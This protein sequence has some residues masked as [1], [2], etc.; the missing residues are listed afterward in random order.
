[1]SHLNFRKYKL[2]HFHQL[3]ASVT[4]LCLLL[5]ACGSETL[6]PP[7]PPPPPAPPPNAAPQ[8]TS[9]ATA[10]VEERSDEVFYTAT[11]T[12]ANNDTITFSLVNSDDSQ[13]FELDV[14][15]GE[16]AFIEEADFETPQDVNQDNVYALTLRADDGIDT[17]DLELSVSVTDVT[18]I[19]V[20]VV[21]VAQGLVNPI[22]ATGA[23][24]NSNRLFVIE[25]EGF[26]RIL[27]LDDNSLNNAPFLDITGDVST[28]FEQGLLGLAF[29][30]DY[31]TSG[32]FY[33]YITNIAGDTE[34]LEYSVSAT[35]P[36]LADPTSRRL[37]LTFA[38]PFAN[39]NAGW[40]GFDSVGDLY[41]TSGD[42]G[43]A[44]DPQNNAQ[45]TD[46]LL[47]TILRIDPMGDDFPADPNANYSIP[48]DNPFVAINGA[49]EIFAYGLRNPFRASFDRNTDNLYIGDVGQNLIEEIDF[50]PVG[51]SGQNF[52]WRILEGSMRF[53]PGDTADLT[54]PITQ[55]PHDSSDTGGFSV[56]GGYVH[57]GSVEALAGQYVFADFISGNIWS[58]PVD[59]LAQGQTFPAADFT[60]QTDILGTPDVSTIGNISSFGEDDDGELYI[61]ELFRGEIFRLEND[62]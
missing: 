40:I 26:V 19:P 18:N 59:N 44:G 62:E 29:P 42:G 54:P 13:F 32:L 14:N 37:I 36:N 8:F 21:R 57:R 4:G 33:I 61:I 16:L 35:N 58:I 5:S 52:G 6:P 51:T 45:N 38:Q 25:Q 3:S 31:E 24:D 39:H 41:I 9:P 17:T 1:L 47:G 22:F 20:R 27:N 12:D 7:P 30:S 28:G 43:G 23:G 10:N 53:S 15:S 2:K 55:Y 56:T 49:D 46:N 11:A 50:I 60:I 48:A 34:I